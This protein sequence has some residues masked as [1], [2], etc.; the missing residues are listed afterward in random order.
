MILKLINQL[1]KLKISQELKDHIT[2]IKEPLNDF[3]PFL[4]DLRNSQAHLDER[5][6]KMQHGKEILTPVFVISST[7]EEEFKYTLGDG[8]LGSI[9]FSYERVKIIQ[10][11]IQALINTLSW[12]SPIENFN[13]K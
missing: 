3:F 4:R 10:S 9:T 5:V 12:V 7:L 2:N 6:L 8:S 11:V 13:N 1:K